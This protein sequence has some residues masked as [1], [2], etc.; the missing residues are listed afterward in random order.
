LFSAV[1]VFIR[2]PPAARK[3]SIHRALPANAVRGI[4]S[5]IMPTDRYFLDPHGAVTRRMRGQPGEGHHDI[6]KEVLPRMGIVPKDYEDHYAQMFKL[7][8]ARIVEH[9]D[10]RVEVEHTCKLSTHQKRYLKTLTSA[11]KTLVYVMVK[12]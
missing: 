3:L 12:R 6:A 4:F 11:G 7:K 2:P 10:G 5:S 1:G 8:F 9:T